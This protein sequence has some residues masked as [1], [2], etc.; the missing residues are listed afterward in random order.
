[1]FIWIGG[2]RFLVEFLRIG[3]WRLGDIPTAQLFGA[4]FVLV[5]LAMLVD[6]PRQ[7]APRLAPVEAESD[8]RRGDDLD[9][10]AAWD[11]LEDDAEAE[12]ADEADAETS[13]RRSTPRRRRTPSHRGDLAGRSAREAAASP[14]PPGGAGARRAAARRRA[15]TGWV[16]RPRRGPRCCTG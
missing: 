16:A 10:D 11:A 15:W 13:R 2:V 8:D 5:G 14:R 9:E 6:P 3:N 1:M 4:A 12:D 7:D